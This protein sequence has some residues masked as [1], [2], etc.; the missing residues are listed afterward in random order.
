M[1]SGNAS[2]LFLVTMVRMSTVSRKSPGSQVTV[3][4]IIIW[5]M[6]TQN[7][8]DNLRW[9]FLQKQLMA[10]SCFKSSSVWASNV[11]FVLLNTCKHNHT[12]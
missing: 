11:A 12:D 6:R 1:V 2:F 10:L 4:R 5:Q 3:H 7:P 9:I 8:I